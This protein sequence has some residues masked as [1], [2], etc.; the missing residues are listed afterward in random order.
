MCNFSGSDGC[1]GSIRLR[2]ANLRKYSN[3]IAFVLQPGKTYG[4]VKKPPYLRHPLTGR[5]GVSVRVGD[6]L[7]ILPHNEE[8]GRDI[9]Y[10]QIL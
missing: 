6:R 9:L 7:I 10:I 4:Y 3:E 1:V 5:C 8:S 2:Y